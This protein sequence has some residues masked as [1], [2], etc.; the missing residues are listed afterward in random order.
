M[1]GLVTLRNIEH[2]FKKY[3]W[4]RTLDPSLTLGFSRSTLSFPLKNHP[5]AEDGGDGGEELPLR[6]AL[7]RPDG[8]GAVAAVGVAVARGGRPR[9]PA[10]DLVVL[11]L[12]LFVAAPC[13][14]WKAS[15]HWQG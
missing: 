12:F 5:R 15:G 10:A 3:F 13:Y 6:A 14:L 1:A 8:D 9:R 11:S 2:T 7:R 4:R